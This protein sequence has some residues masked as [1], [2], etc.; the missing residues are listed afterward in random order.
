MK[1]MNTLRLIPQ[2]GIPHTSIKGDTAD[3]ER[4]QI[5]KLRQKIM[6]VTE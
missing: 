4:E 1:T 3:E 6:E 5:E 2:H